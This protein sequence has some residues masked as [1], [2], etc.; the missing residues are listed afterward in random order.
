MI[1]V[2]YKGRLGNNLIQ[3]AAG[4]ILAEKTGCKLETK[5]F[6]KYSNSGIYKTSSSDKPHI[7]TNFGETFGIAPLSGSVYDNFIALDDKKYFEALNKHQA[8]VGYCLDGFFQ[9][10]RLLCK[11]RDRILKLYHCEKK[12]VKIG[13]DDAFFACRFGD[14]LSNNRTYCSV[15]Y[16]KNHLQQNRKNYRNIYLTSDSLD[17]APLVEI[18]KKYNIIAYNDSPIN[19]ILFAKNF[20]NLILSAG[21][22][23][24]WMAYLSKA[25]NIVIYKSKQDPLQRQ[26]A[27]DYNTNIHFIN[28]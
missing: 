25:S 4:Y 23:S 9:D 16:I 14:C 26:N 2:R 28:S 18:V 8:K 5:P 10:S 22:F 24:Y 13:K 27:W 7:E 21:S 20:N 6:R 17:Y 15:E 19:K 3:Y 11:Y 1:K 12:D